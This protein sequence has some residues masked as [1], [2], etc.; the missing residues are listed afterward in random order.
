[1]TDRPIEMSD[2]E[3]A[4]V[5]V[6]TE[7]DMA[8]AGAFLAAQSRLNITEMLGLYITA[9]ESARLFQV[10]VALGESTIRALG[11]RDDPAAMDA[12]R[13]DINAHAL[14]QAEID[15]EGDTHDQ[16]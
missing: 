10:L 14:K 4:A 1:M 5:A 9:T 7:G 16:A 11:L 3:F 8:F 15:I 13:A 12:L 6:P 2:E